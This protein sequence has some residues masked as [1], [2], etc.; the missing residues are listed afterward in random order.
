MENAVVYARYSSQGQNEQSIDGQLRVCKEFAENKGLNVA[1][2]YIDKAK[3]AWT[4]SEKRVEFQK[5]LNEAE[6]GG[7]KYII[8]YKFDRFSRSRIDSMMYKAQLR[9]KHGIRVISA[10]EPVSDDE[11]GEIYEMFLEW[12]DEKY[13]QRLSKRVRDGLDTSV[14]N[15]TFCGGYLNYGYKIELEPT[16]KAGKF[17]KRVAINEDEAQ[18]V[19]YVFEQYDKGVE[20]KDI[21]KALNEQGHRFKGKPFLGRY[22]DKFIVNEKYTGEFKFGGRVSTNMFPAIIDKALF[23][24]VQERLNKNKYFAGGTATARVPYLLTG[25]IFCGHCETDMVSDGSNKKTMQ[26]RYYSCKKKKKD[27]CDKKREAKDFLENYVVECVREF[28][29]DEANVE[30][31]VNDTLN[32]YDKRTG[33]DSLRSIDMQIV[34]TK[35]EV[36]ELA[37][38]FVKAKSSLLQETIEKKMNDYETLLDDLLTQKAKLEIERGFKIDKKSMMNFIA[39]IL[40]GDPN[41]KEYQRSVIDNLVWAV[42]VSDDDTICRLNMRCSQNV[43]GGETVCY[44]DIRLSVDKVKSVQTHFPPARHSKRDLNPV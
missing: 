14:A 28:L 39:D 13:S 31:A 6:S 8:V 10:T 33:E 16:G 24:R 30:M 18:I 11:G 40:A 32:Y 23:K 17:I 12:N 43:V 27:L 38:A 37:D 29:S 21:A 4:E 15:G 41:D 42:Y 3:S 20:K 25:K 22:F 36:E 5:M 7:F 19:R 26:Y 1:K 2:V 44:N 34:K 35:K 9:K